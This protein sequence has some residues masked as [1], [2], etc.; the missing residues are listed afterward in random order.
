VTARPDT[1]TAEPGATAWVS[2][3]MHPTHFWRIKTRLPERK[4]QPCRVLA[5]GKLNSCLVEFADGK[6]V[7]TSRWSVRKIVA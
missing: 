6:R 1:S 5:R 7:V 2:G 3:T 4:G